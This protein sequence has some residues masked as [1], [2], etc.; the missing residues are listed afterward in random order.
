MEPEQNQS[1]III[2]APHNHKILWIL[3][4]V[5]VLLIIAGLFVFKD[6]IKEKNEVSLVQ[7]VATTTDEFAGW[8]TYR[9]EEYGF[10]FKYPE[11]WLL[12]SEDSQCVS[13]VPCIS[14]S[15][16][17]LI[18][19]ESVYLS[20]VYN[21]SGECKQG[22]YDWGVYGGT[23]IVIEK[24]SCIKGFY[25]YMEVLDN[26]AQKNQNKIQLDRILSTFKFIATSTST[27][28]SNWKT[29]RN[30]EYGFEF[31]YPPVFQTYENGYTMS[32]IDLS[33]DEETDKISVSIDN[34]SINGYELSDSPSGTY[35]QFVQDGIDGKWINKN[36]PQNLNGLPIKK[37]AGDKSLYYEFRGGDDGAVYINAITP[38]KFKNKDNI[39]SFHY[40]FTQV[41][42]KDKT[43]SR[44]DDCGGT[45]KFIK[46]YFETDE[47]I[48]DKIL[49]T[50][51]FT[52]TSTRVPLTENMYDEYAMCLKNKGAVLYG[53]FWSPHTDEQKSRLGS[54]YK[55]LPYVECSTPDA[56]GQT[57][58]CKDKKINVYPTWV[59]ADGS[60]LSGNYTTEQ[61]GIKTGCELPYSV[62]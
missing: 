21:F 1:P 50:F 13:G 22:N 52:Q 39:L 38:I 16:V 9:N 45:F 18:Y 26:D 14:N 4:S 41:L 15:L 34:K 55:Y 59:F 2:Q 54:S 49:S 35:A 32:L 8:K 53:T 51:K 47:L 5:F 12:E 60:R 57:Q 6:K 42:C 33:N 61:L 43:K 25:I 29:Y 19:N 24:L 48:L 7:N 58:I 17:K 27:D 56:M 46:S 40:S 62:Q 23:E 36:N 20:V 44:E 10:E 28:M 11:G 30:E 31:K 3:L 37:Y